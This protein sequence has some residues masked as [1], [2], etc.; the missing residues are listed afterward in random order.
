MGYYTRY[1]VKI[2]GADDE[3][4]TMQILEA[5][6]LHREHR[7]DFSADCTE[8]E[9]L[10]EPQKWYTW[11]RECIYVSRVYPKI[12]IDVYGEGEESG[13]IWK[14]RVRNGESEYVKAKIVFDPFVKLP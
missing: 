3:N 12:T 2:S 9:V 6:E 8:V 14:A 13:D 4:Q 10:T 1:A 7:K 5:L 11:E